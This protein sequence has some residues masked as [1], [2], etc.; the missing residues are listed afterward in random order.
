MLGKRIENFM[1]LARRRLLGIKMNT[2]RACNLS[3][4]AKLHNV[5]ALV[6]T[7]ILKA[8][9]KLL[10]DNNSPVLH[11]KY[12]SLVKSTAAGLAEIPLSE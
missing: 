4:V 3:V 8:L 6:A 9:E 7:S 2:T 1:I 10:R 12:I 11:V 5:S